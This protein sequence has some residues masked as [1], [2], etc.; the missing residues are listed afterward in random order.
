MDSQQQNCLTVHHV[1]MNEVLHH[2]VK[3]GVGLYRLDSSAT[4]QTVTPA[5]TLTH[6]KPA[7]AV[8]AQANQL[9]P[10]SFPITINKPF[11]STYFFNS[12]IK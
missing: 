4:A 1:S 9:I 11:Q 3:C 12:S 10:P 2:F 5:P 6:D 7:A 8:S